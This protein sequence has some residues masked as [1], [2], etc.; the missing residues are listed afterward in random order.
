MST[1]TLTYP[2]IRRDQRTRAI[3]PITILVITS[4]VLIA[5]TILV[6]VIVPNQ[7]PNQA[8][9][10][11]IAVPIPTHP[12]VDIQPIPSETPAPSAS[13]IGQSVVEVPVPTPPLP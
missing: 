1:I 8:D 10:I 2:N 12:T 9:S 7:A 6:I 3:G 4:L 5:A 11:P 13:E